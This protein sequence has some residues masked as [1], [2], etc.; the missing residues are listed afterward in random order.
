MKSCS[1][2]SGQMLEQYTLPYIKVNN[3]IKKNPAADKESM[4]INL[5]SEGINW[6]YK[7][8]PVKYSGT[9]L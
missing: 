1:V 9:K 8:Y 6:K 7:I 4:L 5:N 2:P 3:K